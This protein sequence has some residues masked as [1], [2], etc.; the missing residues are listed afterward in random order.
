MRRYDISEVLG[1]EEQNTAEWQDGYPYFS[2]DTSGKVDSGRCRGGRKA[3]A[4][5]TWS[6]V[7]TGWDGTQMTDRGA[8]EIDRR[9]SIS[10]D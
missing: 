4:A 10:I 9:Y 1:A 5:T 2:P 3:K 6:R 8:V 7:P